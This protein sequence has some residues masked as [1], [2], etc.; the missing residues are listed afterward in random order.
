VEVLLGEPGRPVK[1]GTAGRDWVMEWAGWDGSV[2]V[3]LQDKG[4][5]V[6][7]VPPQEPGFL[8][9]V[10]FRATPLFDRLRRLLPW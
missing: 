7:R 9:S 8:P 1:Y 4:D 3:W 5:G 2:R 10:Q 6:L